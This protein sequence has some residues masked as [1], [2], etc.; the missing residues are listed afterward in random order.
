MRNLY[1][2]TPYKGSTAIGP[3]TTSTEESANELILKG[4][5]ITKEIRN[6]LGSEEERKKRMKKIKPATDIDLKDIKMFEKGKEFEEWW[7]DFKFSIRK[8]GISQIEIQVRYLFLKYMDENINNYIKIATTDEDMTIED[9]ISVVLNFYEIQEKS[10]LKDEKNFMACVKGKNETVASYFLRLQQ[11]S[12]RANIMNEN[13]I[14]EVYLEGLNPA[15][16]LKSVLANTN[17]FSTLQEVHSAAIKSE[18]DYLRV[19]QREKSYPNISNPKEKK[20]YSSKT[21]GIKSQNKLIK[22]INHNNNNNTFNHNSG[23]DKISIPKNYPKKFRMCRFCLKEHDFKECIEKFKY[24]SH[25]EANLITKVG[26]HP[27]KRENHPE[28][29][30]RITINTPW[31]K[32]KLEILAE[33][34]KT[35]NQLTKKV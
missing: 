3:T 22:P 2:S 18:D 26:G 11:L 14:K 4:F 23:N 15:P 12:N 28:E 6:L 20:E 34:E 7:K 31:I 17:K 30:D 8:F 25:E 19:K 16:L 10:L 24:Y 32:R 33:K 1:A 21:I 27:I 9:I 5:N 29:K 35:V 13:K